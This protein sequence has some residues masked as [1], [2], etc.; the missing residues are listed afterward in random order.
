MGA[1]PVEFPAIERVVESAVATGIIPGA[2]M[3]CA[4]DGTTRFHRAFGARQ[5]EP[6]WLPA[7]IRTVYDTASLTKAVCT[8][9]LA[10]RAIADGKLALDDRVA[11]H[12]PEFRGEGKSDVTVRHLLCHAAGLPAHRPFYEAVAPG[13]PAAEAAREI[14]LAAAEEPL[15][16]LPG[17]VSLYSDLGFIL[18]GWVV[19]RVA[20]AEL[21][22]L[23]RRQ[24]FEPLGLSSATFLRVGVGAGG[25][26]EREQFRERHQ[27]APTQ[28][29]PRRGGLVIS[30]VDDLNAFA[31][32]GVAGHAGLFS[33]A[34]DLGKI[35]HALV[36]SWQGQSPG[37]PSVAIVPREVIRELWRPAGIVPGSTWR[38]GWDG[39]AAENSQAGSRMSRAAVGH[40]GFTG[41]SIWIDP[42]AGLW[43]ILLTN[44]VHPVARED[45]RF[46][47]FRTAVHDAA[48]GALADE[49]R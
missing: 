32:G 45:P 27:V 1:E 39:P 21:D 49:R 30:E 4:R 38:L 42:E 35:A 12:L 31:M 26:T 37:D 28:M 36:S 47:G 48:L 13:T 18:L 41:C 2:V 19:A 14:A 7:T 44:R 17:T 20:G 43:I 22:I 40:L 33:D 25:S 10:M 9:V 11:R 29:C 15:V 8:S 16:N 5:L 3:L 34:A 24:M 46:R 6:E 23:F